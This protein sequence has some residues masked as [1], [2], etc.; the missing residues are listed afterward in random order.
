MNCTYCIHCKVKKEDIDQY[1]VYCKKGRWGVAKMRFDHLPR[2][3]EVEKKR[4]A[5]TFFV[6]CPDF[7]EV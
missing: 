2:T 5:H 1:V 7:E 3:Q 6:K 4:G